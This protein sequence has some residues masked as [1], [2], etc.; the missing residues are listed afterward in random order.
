MVGKVRK[1]KKYDYNNEEAAVTACAT[2]VPAGMK[3]KQMCKDM[4]M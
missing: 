2:Y 1:R 3:S 4:N